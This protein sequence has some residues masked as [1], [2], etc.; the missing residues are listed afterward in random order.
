MSLKHKYNPLCLESSLGL[1]VKLQAKEKI[2]GGEPFKTEC[3]NS[4]IL[5]IIHKLISLIAMSDS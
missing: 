1:I 3:V 4:A 5:A 2:R